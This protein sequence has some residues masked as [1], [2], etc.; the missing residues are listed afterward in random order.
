METTT[1]AASAA[2]PTIAQQAV[3]R[4][5]SRVNT[6]LITRQRTEISLLSPPAPPRRNGNIARSFEPRT[7]PIES[8]LKRA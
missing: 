2:I 7:S 8:D 4:S 5:G 1:D 3:P 6:Y